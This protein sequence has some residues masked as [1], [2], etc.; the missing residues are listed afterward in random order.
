MRYKSL[1]LL[2]FI[3]SP[4]SWAGSMGAGCSAYSLDGAC[5]NSAFA[6]GVHA[7]YLQPNSDLYQSSVTLS[8]GS[9]A[10]NLGINPTWSWGFAVNG[11]YFINSEHELLVNWSDY[12]D[13]NSKSYPP[14]SLSYVYPSGTVINAQFDGVYQSTHLEWDQ[15][16][17]EY[18]EHLT[19]SAYNS[20][21][22]HGGGE[23]SRLANNGYNA[24]N[25]Q[26]SINGAQPSLTRFNG[27]YTASYNGFGPRL[28]G[29]FE[30][31]PLDGFNLYAKAA[32]ALLAGTSKSHLTGT[33]GYS[34]NYNHAIVVPQLEGR[35]GAGYTY[36]MNT[37]NLNIDLGW[38]WTNY[39]SVLTSAIS[40]EST[41]TASQSTNF[42]LQGLYL[43]L[44]WLGNVI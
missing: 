7:L 9:S 36:P 5:A 20:V 21:V 25:S 27:Q 26:V 16:N 41:N 44:Q 11:S 37:S 39:F 1:V 22:I 10:V 8:A 34:I 33:Q 14:R 23:F 40:P 38:L 4:L 15:V 28:G 19:L 12:R 35:L 43:G 42:G 17:L 18:A 24:Y 29:D 6:L 32:A 2:G 30:L 31:T 3:C 13:N